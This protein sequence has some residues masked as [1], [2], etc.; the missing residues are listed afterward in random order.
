[1]VKTSEIPTQAAD[2]RIRKRK[3]TKSAQPS[4]NLRSEKKQGKKLNARST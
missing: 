2:R 1:M 3:G 4:E